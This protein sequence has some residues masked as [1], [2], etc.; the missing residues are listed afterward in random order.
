MTQ[1]N[2]SHYHSPVYNANGGPAP[3][4]GG[5]LG[6]QNG[7]ISATSSESSLASGLSESNSINTAATGNVTWRRFGVPLEPSVS[8]GAHSERWNE[9]QTILDDL[10]LYERPFTGPW[11]SLDYRERQDG[12]H[13]GPVASSQLVNENSPNNH[14]RSSPLFYSLAP[15]QT[16]G[17]STV[18]PNCRFEASNDT[19]PTTN[20][21]E[22]PHSSVQICTCS[23]HQ[24]HLEP[25]N[26][27]SSRFGSYL[28]Q[29]TP[30][31]LAR[32][33]SATHVPFPS[34]V[35]NRVSSSEHSG[36]Y[37]DPHEQNSPSTRSVDGDSDLTGLGSPTSSTSGLELSGDVR[38][39]NLIS[40][41]QVP[42]RT[43][44]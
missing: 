25:I 18:C 27:P 21:L 5:F 16:T 30:T 39:V 33:P 8:F 38:A 2:R 11:T 37:Y 13:F 43:W 1:A 24:R 41:D 28:D 12:D 10:A 31:K 19:T 9:P 15:I 4:T 3:F 17:C 23:T 35:F 40:H 26:S 44:I 7:S 42:L 14:D 29:H 36:V 20:T 6:P 22:N 34:L 32:T